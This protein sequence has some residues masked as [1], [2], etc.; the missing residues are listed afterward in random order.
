MPRCRKSLAKPRSVAFNRQSGFCH[1]CGQPMWQK[2]LQ[3]FASRFGI[4]LGLAK[5]FQLTG[6][7]LVAHKDGGTTSRSNIVA[8][9]SFC[10]R[11]RH[12]MKT[13]LDPEQFKRHVQKR[14]GKG[15]WHPVRLC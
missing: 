12:V 6:E 10:N 1:Y 15:Q 3:Q 7:H 5:R 9:C 8:A 4:P 11:T 14:M 2:N 13:V